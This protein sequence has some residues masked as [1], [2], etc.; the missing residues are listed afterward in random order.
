MST[1]QP[2]FFRFV[3]GKWTVRVSVLGLEGWEDNYGCGGKNRW[4][5]GWSELISFARLPKY[6]RQEVLKNKEE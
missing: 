3:S 5:L 2:A 4:A 1:R 6:K